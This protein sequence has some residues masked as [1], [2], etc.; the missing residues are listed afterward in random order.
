MIDLMVNL[1]GDSKI[2]LYQ[3]IYEHI[4]CEM[5]D[6]RISQGERLPSTRM[7][8]KNLS[9][10]RSTVELA[11]EQL[12]A[13]GY[14]KAEPCRGYFACDITELYRLKQ[15]QSVCGRAGDAGEGRR[16]EIEFSPYAID[17]LS[18]PFDV[19]RRLSRTMLQQE[20]EELLYAKD[21][22]GEYELRQAIAVYLHQ[23]RG[24]NCR[25]DEI[26]VGAGNE[27]LELILGQLFGA[28]KRILM[29]NP[30]YP[31]AYHTFC[32]MGYDVVTVDGGHREKL[33]EKLAAKAPDL[34]YVMPSHQ[35]PLGDVMT[36]NLRLQL[37]KW[38]GEEE[39]RYLIE[40]DYDSEYRYRG[41][42]IP[43]MQS[44]DHSGKVVYLG[45]FSRSI[46]PSLRVS[47]MVL[48]PRLMEK[49]R[50][51]CGFYS[52]T[53][54][55]MQ[56][57]ILRTF[58]TEGYFERHLN[59]MRG[60]YK[61]KRDQLRD[62]LK[63]YDW[64]EA[65]RG[66]HAGLHILV[67]I[68]TKMSEQELCLAAKERGLGI[69]GISAYALPPRQAAGPGDREDE[70]GGP[71][72]QDVTLLLGY[73]R[74]DGRQMEKGLKILDELLSDYGSRINSGLRSRNTV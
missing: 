21:G 11:Y 4:K 38:A 61:N 24:V 29:E 47:Y 74:L 46:A 73:G 50:D 42:P 55:K 13:E 22:Q 17:A 49:Y 70:N 67:K 33:M 26:I 36:L 53:V 54:P 20:R 12:L 51:C 14:I 2:P 27:Y 43:S 66:D 56:Q 6:G 58:L 1:Q 31:Q 3:K 45:T 60:I 19:W 64:V 5:E 34:V 8:S 9:V 71:G 48:P 62:Q 63:K 37:I 40:D 16:P 59:K 65:I 15:R 68:K 28:G 39:N 30:G 72:G 18:F 25:P 23:A 10:S 35:F 7:L 52:A 32:A 41:K 69:T 57:E 44:I